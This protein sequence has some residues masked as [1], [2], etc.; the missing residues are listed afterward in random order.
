MKILNKVLLISISLLLLSSM[1]Y[2][3]KSVNHNSARS[4][5]T[6]PIIDIKNA[7]TFSKVEAIQNVQVLIFNK[8]D[9]RQ[10]TNAGTTNNEGVFNFS[11]ESTDQLKN[12]KKEKSAYEM[13]V[14]I[15]QKYYESKLKESKANVVGFEYTVKTNKGDIEYKILIGKNGENPNNPIVKVW[16][17]YQGAS[18]GPYSE[19]QSNL[20]D[21]GIINVE[22]PLDNIYGVEW[23]QGNLSY[24]NVT[25]NVSNKKGDK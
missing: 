18:S 10:K 9:K 1:V 15:P 24:S 22:L 13:H 8:L 11:K 23:N 21:N 2:A 7:P 17:I 20:E 5:M 25:L 16:K 4:N 6:A 3:Q 12:L 14:L 19:S